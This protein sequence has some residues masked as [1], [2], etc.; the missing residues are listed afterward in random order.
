[1]PAPPPPTHAGDVTAAD[2]GSGRGSMA[3]THAQA[4]QAAQA[5]ANVGAQVGPATHTHTHTHTW[6]P[7]RRQRHGWMEACGGEEEE[8]EVGRGMERCSA[9]GDVA[10]R[11]LEHVV[12]GPRTCCA[13]A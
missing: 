10:G 9:L 5:Y 7:A 8:E 11:G 12:P 3:G 13:G 2:D 4:A 6:P 1:M